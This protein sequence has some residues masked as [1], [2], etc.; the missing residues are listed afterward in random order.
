M[1]QKKNDM[2]DKAELVEDPTKQYEKLAK[3][4]EEMGQLQTIEKN[5]SNF[6]S[7]IESELEEKT[8]HDPDLRKSD[9]IDCIKIYFKKIQTEIEKSY[10]KLTSTVREKLYYIIYNIAILFANYIEKMR[11]YNYSIHGVEFLEWVL[12]LMES[13]IVLSHVKYMKL[14]TQLYLLIG[15]LYEDCKGFKAAYGFIT[16]GINKLTDLKSVEEQERPLPDYMQD[17]FNENFKHLRYFEFKY[18]I[19]SGNLNFESWKKN[20]KKLMTQMLKM[21]K[22]KK[23]IRIK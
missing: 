14:R 17:I 18:G 1:K 21:Q 20:W 12:T 9:T 15:F 3:I 22:I 23:K 16:Q 10:I 13:N 11:K 19:L 6:I 5:L 4:D 2:V 8:S 7:N